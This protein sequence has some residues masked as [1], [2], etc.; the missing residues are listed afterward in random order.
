M[1]SSYSPTAIIIGA[2]PGGISMA[3]RLKHELGFNDFLVNPTIRS[4]ARSGLLTF[5]RYMKSW[6]G[7]EV[8]GDRTPIRAGMIDGIIQAPKIY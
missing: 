7:W 1:A 5:Y 6:M 3:Y 2:G 8:L 4:S